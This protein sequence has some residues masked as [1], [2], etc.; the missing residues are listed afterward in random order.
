MCAGVDTPGLSKIVGRF[1]AS[2][3]TKTS[4]DHEDFSGARTRSGGRLGSAVLTPGEK[5]PT[6]R[7]KIAA[8][9]RCRSTRWI[10]VPVHPRA[11]NPVEFTFATVRLRQRGRQRTPPRPAGPFGAVSKKGKLVSRL[12]P[13]G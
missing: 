8:G 11:A 12:I 3:D 5:P 9:S 2:G 1:G 4:V 10:P 7:L 6:S 13:P